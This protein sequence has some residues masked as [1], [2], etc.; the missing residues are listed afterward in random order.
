V[1]VILTKKGDQIFVDD[2]DYDLVS[3]YSWRLDNYGYAVTTIRHNGK[4]TTQKM[5]RMIL[6]V[7][8]SKIQVDHIDGNKADN[9]RSN[10]RLC[11]PAENKR[12]RGPQKNCQSGIKGLYYLKHK[13]R[14]KAE[15]KLNGKSHTKYYACNKYPDA[16][17][18]AI[19]WLEENREKLHGQFARS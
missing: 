9:R 3:G 12:N 4:R 6:C 2:C 5:H 11:T 7:T 19:K 15:I 17:G 1:A 14:W 10:I 13:N 18:L 16:K 8:D